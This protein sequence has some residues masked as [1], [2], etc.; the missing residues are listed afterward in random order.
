MRE[1]HARVRLELVRLGVQLDVAEREIARAVVGVAPCKRMHARN[2]L[3]HSERLGK[4]VV[5]TGH[6]PVD[7]VIDLCLRR[8]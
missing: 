7:A 8:E 3:L 2:E 4:V 5:S 6:E 1:A